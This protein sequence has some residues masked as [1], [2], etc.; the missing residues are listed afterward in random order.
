VVGN[1]KSNVFKVFLIFTALAFLLG[2]CKDVSTVNSKQA[3]IK[4][5]KVKLKE[6]QAQ[7][8]MQFDLNAPQNSNE[9]KLWI[10]YPVSDENQN[11]ED[12]RVSGNFANSGVYRESEYGNMVLFAQW[13]GPSKKRLLTYAFKIKRKEVA[14]N[15]IPAEEPPFSK[16]EFN[17]YLKATSRAPITGKVKK[18]AEKVTEGKNTNLTKARAIYD[19]IINN[20]A[21]D[22]NIKGC[23][24]GECKEL[25]TVKSG[26]CADI[27]G[28]FVAMARS[29][30]MPAREIYGIRILKDKEGDTTQKQHCWAQFYQPGF[31]WVTVDPAD[32]LKYKLE[33]K[34][35]NLKDM[36]NIVEYFFSSVDQNRIAYQ[37]G[38]DVTLN[39]P[40]NG[41]K[42]NYFMYPYAEA[43]GQTLNE[44]LYGF[45]VGY[46]IS[47]KEL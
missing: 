10:P 32:V 43:D 26:K 46:K 5:K 35:K 30:G 42:L 36:K 2:G 7:V 38:R 34:I 28:V 23:G 9:V 39:P 24:S 25:L 13:E 45:N 47:F 16:E 27:S 18:Q 33:N 1:F 44:D 15:N 8:T 17:T 40:Q 20:M 29:V 21:R 4:N 11:I 12:V 31:G 6:R 22:P 14:S 37:T 19:W 3:N 41:G